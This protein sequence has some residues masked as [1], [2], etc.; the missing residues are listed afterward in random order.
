MP[1]VLL[2]DVV[3]RIKDKVDKDNTD[4]KYYI[5]GEHFDSG[6]IQITKKGIIKESTIGPAFHMRFQPGDVLLM[7]RNP[8]L[9]KA[10][11]VDFEG[12]C[13]DVSYVC[14]TKDE[15]VLMQRFIPFIFQ[16]DH[17]WKFAEENKK[18]S[19]NFFLNWSDFEKYEFEL[20]QIDEQKKLC[21]M[22]WAFEDT[23]SAYKDLLL[24]TDELVKSQFIEM[25]GDPLSENSYYKKISILDACDNITGGGTPS[26]KHPE[27]YEGNIPWVSPKDMNT[28]IIEDSQDHIT[29]EAI[30]KSTTKLI[31]EQS[32]LMVIRSGVLKHDLPIA[33]NKVPVTINQ[34]MK[35]F[36]V[37]SKI[38]PQYLFG[39]FKTIEADVLRGVRAVTADNIEFKVFQERLIQIP[40]MGEQ[41]K[42]AEFMIQTDKS[43]FELKQAIEDIN[44][45]MRVFMAQNTD[46]E[47]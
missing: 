4:L 12:I 35:A 30:T 43:K 34:D 40:P 13:S 32:V 24:Q 10:G 37:G 22:M 46:K 31:P 21:E 44:N 29:E 27:Y 5:G 18:G 33:I 45:L 47:D 42:F 15:N 38:I 11:I 3:A 39:Y 9:R 2:K 7:S 19:T 16:T 41:K 25:F 23:K 28:S 20:P 17:F 36:L 1:K 6:E 26:K 8:H 14:R